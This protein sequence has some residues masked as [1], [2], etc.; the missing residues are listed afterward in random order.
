M[1]LAEVSL[2]FLV[3]VWV[4]HG[5]HAV[6]VCGASVLQKE[7]ISEGKLKTKQEIWRMVLSSAGLC[8]N[9]TWEVAFPAEQHRCQLVLGSYPLLNMLVCFISLLR[10]YLL[11]V[12]FSAQSQRQPAEGERGRS[13][14]W[15]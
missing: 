7:L 13:G 8:F 11:F 2:H 14:V 5:T 6:I 10:L 9:D 15:R 12:S 4:M 3:S 1:K